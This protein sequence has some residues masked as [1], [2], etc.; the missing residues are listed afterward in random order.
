M[1]LVP[2]FEQK[3]NNFRPRKIWPKVVQNLEKTRFMQLSRIFFSTQITRIPG[4]AEM[5]GVGV[6]NFFFSK[7]AQ[8]RFLII[9]INFWKKK[10]LSKGNQREIF[11]WVKKKLLFLKVA[12][13]LRKNWFRRTLEKKIFSIFRTF[14][15]L[16]GAN[17][18]IFVY[19][20][21]GIIWT[22]TRR[23]SPNASSMQTTTRR[24]LVVP[25]RW[26]SIRTTA[27]TG[28]GS[29]EGSRRW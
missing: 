28:C 27:S 6:E 25:F 4:D 24:A 17:F 16:L 3:N 19:L 10:F 26:S 22:G 14:P 13:N 8:N 11:F 29:C 1:P 23:A 2:P 21:A 9:L 15:H 20:Q 12:K 18:W 7:V 5:L